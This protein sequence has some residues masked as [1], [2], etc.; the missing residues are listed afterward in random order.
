MPGAPA[1][2]ANVFCIVLNPPSVGGVMQDLL[3]TSV[4]QH[5]LPGSARHASAML[6]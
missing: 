3:V 4:Y 2:N 5:S 1:A 6:S